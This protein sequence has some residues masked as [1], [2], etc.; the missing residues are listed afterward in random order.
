MNLESSVAQGSKEVVLYFH[1]LN[2]DD[3][4]YEE[5]IIS[6]RVN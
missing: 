6:E 2:D 5:K 1:K 3:D 4:E